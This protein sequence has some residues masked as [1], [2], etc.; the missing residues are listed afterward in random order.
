[1]EQRSQLV[2]QFKDPTGLNPVTQVD[3]DIGETFQEAFAGQ[4]GQE[5]YLV[6]EE[7]LLS[8]R[9]V[10]VF[11]HMRRYLRLLVAVDPID[12]TLGY[13]VRHNDDW[14]VMATLF[15]PEVRV[16]YSRV[17]MPSAGLDFRL[18][19]PEGI[20]TRA[21]GA[22]EMMATI[23]KEG[24]GATVRLAEREIHLREQMERAGLVVEI[25]HS[26]AGMA[27]ALARGEVSMITFPSLGGL[28]D[29]APAMAIAEKNGYVAFFASKPEK[30]LKV[31]REMLT[32][33]WQ[34]H[35]TLIITS[36][37]LR[38]RLVLTA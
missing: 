19:G 5:L 9:P 10:E 15:D 13:G 26:A 37:G 21:D 17:V 12:G 20:I 4:I 36:E 3:A 33:R 24:Q 27:L 18:E 31:G 29:I 1:M 30:K 28:W 25:S 38:K 6:E 2:V 32:D 7:H 11:R 16:L 22:V 35:D 34:M 14:G 8:E 23:L